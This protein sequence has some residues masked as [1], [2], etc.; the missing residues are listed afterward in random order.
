MKKRTIDLFQS[1][2]SLGIA[3]LTSFG[4][5]PSPCAGTRHFTWRL[6][7]RTCGSPPAPQVSAAI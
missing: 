4:L 2:T 6:S 7:R 5:V 3:A 1:T